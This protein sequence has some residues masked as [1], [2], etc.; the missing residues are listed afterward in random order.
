VV[1]LAIAFRLV[2]IAA[3]AL[4]TLVAL[5]LPRPKVVAPS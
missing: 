5:A 2:F 3:E 4:M 1:V